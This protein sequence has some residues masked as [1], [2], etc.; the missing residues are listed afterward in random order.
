MKRSR[1]HSTRKQVS[2]STSAAL[3]A[4]PDRTPFF[5]CLIHAS[6]MLVL[7]ANVPYAH[8]NVFIPGIR[9]SIAWC[10]D[11]A[12]HCRLFQVILI[13]RKTL[14]SMVPSTVILSHRSILRAGKSSHSLPTSFS[15]LPHSVFVEAGSFEETIFKGIAFR[16]V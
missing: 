1:C 12:Y 4:S 7:S 5:D 6:S 10:Q 14:E 2:P 8:W 9:A 3:L 16:T 15:P 11:V 13:F